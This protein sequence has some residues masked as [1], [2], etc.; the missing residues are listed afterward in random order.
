MDEVKQNEGDGIQGTPEQAAAVYAPKHYAVMA[1]GVGILAVGVVSAVMYLG[2]T[3]ERVD[4]WRSSVAE[5]LGMP[6]GRPLA[7]GHEGVYGTE[8]GKKNE[9]GAG[10]GVRVAEEG[11]CGG[12]V[13][14]SGRWR[15]CVPHLAFETSPG[16]TCAMWSRGEKIRSHS[17]AHFLGSTGRYVSPLPLMW[18]L[19]I[20]SLPVHRVAVNA[21][22]VAPHVL[23]DAAW[24]PHGIA[25]VGV[26]P[27]VD[28]EEG[29]AV[30]E[31]RPDG[32]GWV[33]L[34]ESGHVRDS[35]NFAI[36]TE[37]A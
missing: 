21:N 20:P 17:V 15:K 28:H 11:V 23:D 30:A 37:S 22:V 24:E 5:A 3:S 32:E 29:V 33:E 31:W 36:L 1:A 6:P 12:R 2:V 18:H 19:D 8:S 4:A 35:L 27:V 34:E 7:L 16:R 25:R 9:N 26:R 13:S 10:R 14:G